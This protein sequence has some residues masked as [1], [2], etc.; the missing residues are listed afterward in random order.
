MLGHLYPGQPVRNTKDQIM[1][2]QNINAET[3]DR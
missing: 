2:Y 3:I 1:N